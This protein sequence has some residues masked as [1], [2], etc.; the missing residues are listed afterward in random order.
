MSWWNLGELDHPEGPTNPLN[1]QEN[2]Y[3]PS[4]KM[5]PN[6]DLLPRHERWGNTREYTVGLGY[7]LIQSERDPN[8]QQK[9]WN[10]VWLPFGLPKVNFFSWL[11]GH[12]K[13]PTRENMAKRGLL[14]PHRCL[15]CC[16]YLETIDHLFLECNFS[17]QFWTLLLKYLHIAAPNNT[18]F[19]QLFNSC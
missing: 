13:I 4:L 12:K 14:G 5:H 19:P 10:M 3:K 9:L 6:S 17:L 18:I 7:K 8:S 2:P 16:K 11:P 15:L 1:S